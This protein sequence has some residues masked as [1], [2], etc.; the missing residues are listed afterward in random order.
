LNQLQTKNRIN[1]IKQELSTIESELKSMPPGKF[2]STINGNNTK[3][4]Y[5]LDNKPSYLPKKERALAQKLAQKNYLENKKSILQREL[6]SLKY[7]S[8]YHLDNYQSEIDS[9]LID[10]RYKN[11]F[12]LEYEY[13]NNNDSK[14]KAAKEW[15]SE[16]Y[17]TN[18][19]HPEK[20]T[21][22]T[23]SGIKVRSKSEELIANL[24]FHKHIPFRY[25][26]QL[27]LEGRAF[28][29]DFTLLNQID[30]SIWYLE[31]LGMMDNPQYV[32]SFTN[33]LQIFCR[34]GII[35]DVNL[36]LTYETDMNFL[37]INLLNQKLDYFFGDGNL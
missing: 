26:C 34:N 13:K 20:L 9:L 35:P 8:K 18:P 6:K 29:P 5:V 30:N 36:I 10:P 15:L 16:S 33:K 2:Y 4:F 11:L 25:E 14:I 21:H 28:Y 17:E 32:T 19:S 23:L 1:I 27:I 3:W 12:P 24:L 31:H 22:N 37:D 7:Y